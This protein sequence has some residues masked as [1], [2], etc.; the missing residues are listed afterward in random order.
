MLSRGGQNKVLIGL[1]GMKTNV[2]FP[3]LLKIDLHRFS[4]LDH[5]GN[6]PNSSLEMLTKRDWPRKKISKESIFL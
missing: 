3:R 5:A 4:F 1:Y 2:T 6:S